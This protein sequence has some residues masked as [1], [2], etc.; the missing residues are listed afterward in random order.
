MDEFGYPS[1]GAG[2]HLRPFDI[3]S[4]LLAFALSLA[5]CL[6]SVSRMSQIGPDVGTFVAFEPGGGI[7]HWQQPGIPARFAAG[8]AV[9]RH[10]SLLPSVISAN[11][12]SF[13][14]EAKE[15]TQ[16][17][18]YRVHWS[19]QHTD[20]GADDCGGVADLTPSLNELRAL[21]TVAGGFGPRRGFSLF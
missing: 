19:G 1:D 16:P 6:L 13:V 9:G 8:E 5:T 7:R 4:Y 10:C 21:A 15:L 18:L 14:V 12:G 11:G 20:R 2:E 3:L 17:P